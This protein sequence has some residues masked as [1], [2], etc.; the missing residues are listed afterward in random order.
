MRLMKTKEAAEYIGIC[1][2][3]LR[4]WTNEGKPITHMVDPITGYRYFTAEDLDE[5]MR[6]IRKVSGKE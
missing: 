4:K 3:T 6:S 2:N 5:F 1:A